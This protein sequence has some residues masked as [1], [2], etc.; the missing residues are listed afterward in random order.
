MAKPQLSK[1]QHET[2]FEPFLE[3]IKVELERLSGGDAELLRALRVELA[4]E[5]KSPE[6][7]DPAAHNNLKMEIWAQ[8]KGICPI[9][10]ELLPE[11]NAEMDRFEAVQGYTAEN[12]RLVHPA[13]YAAE[14][15]RR[16]YIC[17][18]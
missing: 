7:G 10:N 16:G 4:M 15:V 9:C 13:C 2:L 11:E 3:H 12:T 8:Q 18:S 6:R 1:E 14:Q 5:L 17:R